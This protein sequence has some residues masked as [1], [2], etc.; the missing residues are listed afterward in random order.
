MCDVF[1]WI[2]SGLPIGGRIGTYESIYRHTV[3]ILQSLQRGLILW[4]MWENW[5][6]LILLVY[7]FR[8]AGC[9]EQSSPDLMFYY[10]NLRNRYLPTEITKLRQQTFEFGFFQKF[11]FQQYSKIWVI[12]L[13]LWLKA[14][15]NFGNT[16]SVKH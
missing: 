13:C 6:F 12:L 2:R 3:H 14:V 8:F 7:K 10:T 16:S 4:W 1:Q 9:R 15:K 5:L 11:K